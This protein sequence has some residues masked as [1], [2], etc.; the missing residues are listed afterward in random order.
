MF[1][2]QPIGF[3]HYFSIQ[4]AKIPTDVYHSFY[5]SWEDALWDLLERFNIPYHATVLV[6]EFY[7]IEVINNMKAHGL[8]PIFYPMD[9]YFHTDPEIFETY[10]RRYRPS[11]VVI[12]HAVGMTN[13][14]LTNT[15][16]WIKSLPLSSLLI[17]DCVHRIVDPTKIEFLTDRHFTIDSLRKV[18]PLPG[19]NLYCSKPLP[20]KPASKSSISIY[21]YQVLGWWIIFQLLL[22]LGGITTISRLKTYF[23]AIAEQAMVKGYCLIG[24][25]KG[26]GKG[27]WLFEKL[28][29]H[30]NFTKIH[31]IKQ[32]QALTYTEK[33][34]MLSHSKLSFLFPI[35]PKDYQ[36]L[37]GFPVGLFLVNS[38]KILE[39]LR[40]SGLFVRFELND[41]LWSKKYK[42]IYLPMGLHISLKDIETICAIFKQSLQ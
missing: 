40:N 14:L 28:A 34:H 21:R 3:H 33:L 15:E 16:T 32:Q 19:S 29:Q 6:P 2:V 30:L 18:I 20:T 37:R 25:K 39:N 35:D 31:Q 11:I 8:L 42:V 22:F 41:C 17:E 7:C 12:F 26:S 36:E 27:W 1:A 38:S 23:F 9:Q 13:N 4:Q 5:A 24:T 10:V